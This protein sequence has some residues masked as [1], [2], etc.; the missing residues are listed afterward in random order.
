MSKEHLAEERLAGKLINGEQKLF[1]NLCS[2][3]IY[4]VNAS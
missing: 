3:D 4:A 1:E 2:G